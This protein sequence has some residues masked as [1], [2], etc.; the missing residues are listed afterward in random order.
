MQSK[1]I[2]VIDNKI[3]YQHSNSKNEV[4][5]GNEENK[6]V[7]IYTRIS[8]TLGVRFKSGAPHPNPNVKKVSYF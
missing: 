7:W 2:S 1:V 3:S 8:Y 5:F 6:L 4:K